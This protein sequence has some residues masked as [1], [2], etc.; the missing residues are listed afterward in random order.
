ML[1][2]FLF[3][4]LFLISQQFKGHNVKWLKIRLFSID[5][6]LRWLDNLIFGPF[7]ATIF[8]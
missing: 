3:P 5:A 7:Y 4:T 6:T 1:G 2:G 8:E